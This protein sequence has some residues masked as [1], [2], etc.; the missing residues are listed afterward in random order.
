MSS[1]RFQPLPGPVDVS[2][3]ELFHQSAHAAPE[4]EEPAHPG[5]VVEKAAQLG[6][7]LAR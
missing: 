1:Y 3:P 4:T 6:P 2:G 7:P 5:P